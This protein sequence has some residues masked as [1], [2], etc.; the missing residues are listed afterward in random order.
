MEVYL[1]KICAH[2]VQSNVYWRSR[3]SVW[4][5]IMMDGDVTIERVMR[6]DVELYK[7]YLH[8]IQNAYWM[9][10]VF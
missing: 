8:I 3:R 2:N 4:F 7:R 6:F 1:Q 5:L 9:H 10:I